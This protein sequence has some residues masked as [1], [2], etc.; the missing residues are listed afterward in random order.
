M[1]KIF[2]ALMMCVALSAGAKVGD[3]TPLSADRI[4]EVKQEKSKTA[5]G[6]EKVEIVVIYKDSKGHRKMASMTKT[7]YK[8]LEQAKK[9]NTYLEYEL[10]EG[11][12]KMKIQVK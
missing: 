11:K 3:V 8:K 6:T 2:M 5:K 9:Y 7:D 12:T 1:K 10:V 4:L